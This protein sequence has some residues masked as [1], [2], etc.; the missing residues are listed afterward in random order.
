MP[1]I[2]IFRDP[3]TNMPSWAVIHDLPEGESLDRAEGRTDLVDQVCTFMTK[4]GGP[5]SSVLAAGDATIEVL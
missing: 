4:A 5:E 3:A 2:Q 1:H